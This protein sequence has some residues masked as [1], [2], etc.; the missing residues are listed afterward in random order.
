LREEEEE[1]TRREEGRRRIKKVARPTIVGIMW[2]ICIYVSSDWGE[3]EATRRDRRSTNRRRRSINSIR[4]AGKIGDTVGRKCVCC[5]REVDVIG[6]LPVSD[7]LPTT[8]RM[9]PTTA[10]AIALPRAA[11]AILGAHPCAA[12]AAA[13]AAVAAAVAAAASAAA[14]AAFFAFSFSAASL[15]WRSVLRFIYFYYFIFIFYLFLN[16][17]KI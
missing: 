10:V 17:E 1:A 12:S 16:L 2:I 14:A 7:A 6:R 8:Y 15:H 13:A 3:E 9:P 4:P 5:L 11:V